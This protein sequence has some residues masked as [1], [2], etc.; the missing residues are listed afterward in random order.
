MGN[1][2]LLTLS[3]PTL[4]AETHKE[5]ARGTAAMSVGGTSVID[6]QSVVDSRNS[7]LKRT[8]LVEKTCAV[9]LGLCMFVW[10]KPVVLTCRDSNTSA[11]FQVRVDSFIHV[12]RLLHWCD[13]RP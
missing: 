1:L 10:S 12:A 6:G 13:F 3:K 9:A 8:S 4:V 2:D 11:V 7:G 5:S